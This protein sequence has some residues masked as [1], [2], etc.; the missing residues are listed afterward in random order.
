MVWKLIVA[1]SSRPSEK[2]FHGMEIIVRLVFQDPKRLT[3]SLS[4]QPYVSCI[5]CTNYSH[6]NHSLIMTRKRRK[7]SANYAIQKREHNLNDC[8]SKNDKGVYLYVRS[9]FSKNQTNLA[10]KC[11]CNLKKNID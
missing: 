4:V 3:F 5:L 9:T 7:F 10:P 11:L 8:C 1:S 6:F 2:F